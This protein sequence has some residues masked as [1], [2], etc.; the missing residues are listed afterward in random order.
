VEI[1]ELVIVETKYYAMVVMKKKGG[2]VV[3]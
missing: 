2:I 3:A 1:T